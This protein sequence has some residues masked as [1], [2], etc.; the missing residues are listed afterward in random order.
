[1]YMVERRRGTPFA[2]TRSREKRHSS[3]EGEPGAKQPASREPPR[4]FS[5]VSPDHAIICSSFFITFWNH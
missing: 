3:R 5:E 2:A 4:A 1:M